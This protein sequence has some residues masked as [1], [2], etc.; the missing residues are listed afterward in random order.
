[1]SLPAALATWA[2]ACTTRDEGGTFAAL[3]PAEAADLEAI[4]SC[5][6]PSD[7]SHG[8]VEAGVI[9]FIDAAL[10]GL[11]SDSLEPVR[12]GLEDLQAR[13][14][15]EHGDT[16]FAELEEG[17]QVGML[18]SID[19]TDFFATVRHL[20]LAGMFSHPSHGGNRG[21]VGWTLVGFDAQGPTPPP[22]GYYDAD[23]AERGA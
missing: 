2:S 15:R 13:V 5:I 7:D 21:E 18:R 6:I 10:A 17:A 3:S 9:H 14:A 20:T 1:M 23:Y 8:A 22:F 12:A 19:D 4:A 16:S 11:R